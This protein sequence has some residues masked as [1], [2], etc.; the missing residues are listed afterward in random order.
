MTDTRRTNDAKRTAR[1]GRLP[2]AA[3]IAAVAMLVAGC[4]SVQP[5]EKGFLARP[6]MS[7]DADPLQARLE[8]GVYFSK[9]GATGGHGVGGG[10]CGCN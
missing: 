6:D 5:W 3:A 2:I 10:G 9:E 8:R 1:S 4:S 7:F